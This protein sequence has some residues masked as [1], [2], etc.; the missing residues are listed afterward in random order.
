MTRTGASPLGVRRP[1]SFEQDVVQS[2]DASPHVTTSTHELLSAL[3]NLRDGTAWHALRVELD[4]TGSASVPHELVDHVYRIVQECLNNI[5][6]HAH[7]RCARVS[8][9]VCFDRVW[10]TVAD[11]G[12]GF[13][14]N[15]RYWL[16]DLLHRRFGPVSVRDRVAALGGDMVLSSNES[17]SQLDVALPLRP[18]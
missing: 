2:R 16:L 4:V 18:G 11:D 15:G 13:P 8:V 5:A 10:I 17:G 12:A 6:R 14:C 9:R 7:A 3:N 1:M